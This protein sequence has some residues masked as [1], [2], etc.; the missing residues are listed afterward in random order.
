MK[1]TNFSRMKAYRNDGRLSVI[2]KLSLPILKQENEAEEAKVS[3]F[4]SFYLALAERY[5]SLVSASTLGDR[6]MGSVA[7][8]TVGYDIDAAD[9]GRYKKAIQK[10]RDPI[11]IRRYVRINS[12]STIKQSACIDIYDASLGVFVK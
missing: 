3:A 4:N 10:C 12:S 11:V 9:L 5:L 2:L 1:I 8:V 7:S 6:E